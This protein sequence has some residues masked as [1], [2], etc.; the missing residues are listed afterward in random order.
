MNTFQLVCQAQSAV[1]TSGPLNNSVT[2]V[3]LFQVLLPDH[4][5]AH[6]INHSNASALGVQMHLHLITSYTCY[7]NRSYACCTRAGMTAKITQAHL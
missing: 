1:C 7:L 6:L 4:L 5:Q 3:S 2:I